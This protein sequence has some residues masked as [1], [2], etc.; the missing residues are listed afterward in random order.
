MGGAWKTSNKGPWTMVMIIHGFPNDIA[1]LRFEW[2]WQH[3]HDS[4]R[5][6]HVAK[7]KSKEK[8]F[9]F[10]LRVLSEMLRVGPWRRLPLTI[11]WL[12]QELARDFPIERLPPMHMPICYGPVVS[13]KLPKTTQ[14]SPEKTDNTNYCNLCF[15]LV[16]QKSVKCI[17]GACNLNSHLTCLSK[18]FLEK[19]EYVPIEGNCPK[20]DRTFLW[21]DI[22]RKYK[23]CYSNLDVTINVDLANGFYSSDSD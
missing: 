9:D 2:A 21:G 20:C 6:K 14:E 23:G 22:V 15:S 11:R 17:N 4:R 13:K 18:H 12:N 3:P 16:E 5:L 7:K 1:A 19:G 8:T 10:C